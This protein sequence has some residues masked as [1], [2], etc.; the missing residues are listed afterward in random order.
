MFSLFLSWIIQPKNA[1]LTA[2]ILAFLT[3]FA[4]DRYLQHEV[5]VRDENIVILNNNIS[6]LKA[7]IE[8]QNL[9][10]KKINEDFEIQKNNFEKEYKDLEEK[11]KSKISYIKKQSE[12]QSPKD[13]NEVDATRKVFNDFKN[14]RLGV[15]K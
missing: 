12:Y 4:H 9:S 2:I 3:L 1:I 8:L 14:M 10:I 7:S 15:K 5:N 6:E 11:N 13:I